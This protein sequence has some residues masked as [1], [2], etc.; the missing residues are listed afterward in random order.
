MKEWETL[1]TVKKVNKTKIY[2]SNQSN[3]Y[4]KIKPEDRK[5][6]W[7]GAERQKLLYPRF[8]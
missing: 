4:R 8:T 1:E 2:I 7:F 5:L 6:S 3:A